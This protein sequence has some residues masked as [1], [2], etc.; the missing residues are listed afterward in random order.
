[1]RQCFPKEYRGGNIIF[2]IDLSNY[3]TNTDLQKAPG[4]DRSNFAAK[5]DLASLK[6]ELDKTEFEKLKTIPF[7]LNKLCNVVKKEVIK[8]LC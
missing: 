3:V 6:T 1:M 5:P 7:A 4:V 2:K 8:K